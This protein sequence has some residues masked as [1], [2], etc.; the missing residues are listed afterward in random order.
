MYVHFAKQ[1]IITATPETLIIKSDRRWFASDAEKQLCILQPMQQQQ[2]NQRAEKNYKAKKS[3][4]T[5]TSKS[6]FIISI[7]KSRFLLA[8]ERLEV[9]ES[10]T[11]WACTMYNVT[12]TLV[13]VS[14]VQ[15]FDHIQNMLCLGGVL[16]LLP[17]LCNDNKLLHVEKSMAFFRQFL[18]ALD[19]TCA[20]I[21]CVGDSY[22]LFL[23][24][25]YNSRIISFHV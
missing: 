17:R 1:P 22:F 16:N 2:Q 13:Y 18:F 25:N 5:W 10:R 21:Y 19:W 14:C 24:F 15:N 12:R 3:Q 4:R 11:R 8:I 23:L 6:T 9:K 20:T 7:L